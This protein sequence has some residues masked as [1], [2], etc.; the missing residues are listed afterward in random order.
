MD[1]GEREKELKHMKEQNTLSHHLRQIF[2]CF[3]APCITHTH[4]TQLTNPTCIYSTSKGPLTTQAF[5][6][7][8]TETLK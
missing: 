1:R 6:R 4:Y 5:E 7:G 8:A 3:S 2:K